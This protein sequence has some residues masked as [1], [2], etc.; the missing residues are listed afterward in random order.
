MRVRKPQPPT[1]E[2]SLGSR[3]YSDG[4]SFWRQW[5]LRNVRQ[6]LFITYNCQIGSRGIEDGPVRKI[7]ASLLAKS[8]DG[9]EHAAAPDTAA[10]AR[11]PYSGAG[12]PQAVSRTLT[13]SWPLALEVSPLRELKFLD[14]YDGQTLDELIPL[15]KT[16][17]TDSLVLA[18]E[19]ALDRKVERIGLTSLSQEERVILAVEA[20]EREVNNGGYEQFF[21]N[22]SGAYAD[23]V[24]SALRAIGCPKQAGI[25]KRALGALKINGKATERAI[26]KALAKGGDTLAEKLSDCDEAF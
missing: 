12:E 26:Q 13:G 11:A 21:G 20:L 15:E 5:Y 6:M 16:H 19:A 14:N 3:S 2:I 18:M 24:E 10:V 25:A 22:S 4:D 1:Q 23:E 7:L 8:H 17:R 9:R